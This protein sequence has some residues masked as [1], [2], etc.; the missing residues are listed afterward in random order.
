MFITGSTIRVTPISYPVAIKLGY[1][2]KR[3]I[4][5]HVVPNPS[6]S[7]SYDRGGDFRTKIKG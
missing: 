2:L 1:D 6:Q 3:K 4:R 5:I 7:S